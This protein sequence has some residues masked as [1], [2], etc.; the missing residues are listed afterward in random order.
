M[1][2]HWQHSSATLQG[3]SELPSRPEAGGSQLWHGVPCLMLTVP[4]VV[5]DG[6]CHAPEHSS[7][8]ARHTHET[9]LCPC[10]HC[11]VVS[12]LCDVAHWALEVQHARMCADDVLE[13]PVLEVR[14][15]AIPA[16]FEVEQHTQ[17]T[18]TDSAPAQTN[19][20]SAL[21]VCAGPSAAADLG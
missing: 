19:C 1:N 18:C 14:V 17:C 4:L 6:A 20:S 5:E 13:Q 2:T 3:P 9:Q 15:G 11:R 7:L 21:C 10:N 8:Y 16:S 12:F